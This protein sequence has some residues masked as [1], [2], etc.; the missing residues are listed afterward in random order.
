MGKINTYIYGGLLGCIAILLFLSSSL[1]WFYEQKTQE[2]AKLKSEKQILIQNEKV[3]QEAIDSLNNMVKELEVKETLID[4]SK[5][6]GIQIRDESCASQLEAY[7]SLFKE[8]G[9]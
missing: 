5:L 3:L 7:K 1:W 4:N 2:I 8:L 6:L 9:D